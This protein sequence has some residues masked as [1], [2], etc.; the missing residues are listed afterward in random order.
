MRKFLI[1]VSGARPEILDRCPT[2]R[3][4]FQSL[5]LL[6]LIAGGAAAV[7]MWFALTSALGL[8]LF[9]AV[10]VALLA[11]L[12]VTAIDRWLV[13]SI[14]S[15]S[16]RRWMIAIPRLVMAMLLGIVI[17]TPLVLR[18]FQPEINAQIAV[19]KQQQVSAFLEQQQHSPISEQITY[20]RSR[21][22]GLQN[23]VDSDGDVP[24]NLAI[25]P[26]VRSLTTQL[27]TEQHLKQQ[28]YKQW[29]CQLYGEKGCL[30]GNGQLARAN[31]LAY[32]EA[33]VQVA[34]LTG[35]I[36]VREDQLLK[37]AAASKQLRYQQASS[38]LPR[39]EQQLAEV[40][41]AQNELLRDFN[42]QNNSS[43]GLLIRL[44]ALNELSSSNLTV[45][46][47][48]LLVFFLFLIIEISPTIVKL[49]QRDGNYEKILHIAAEQELREA[50]R[51]AYRTRPGIPQIPSPDVDWAASK[52]AGIGEIWS[53][54]RHAQLGRTP[55]DEGTHGGRA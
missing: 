54:V 36:H 7:S 24:I 38:E 45:N 53:H 23:V 29:Q 52:E 20:W 31:Q 46:V 50:R 39:A 12:V 25:D 13:I 47:S 28:Y 41:Q 17:S 1:T 42:T 33:A 16:A 51:R 2:D 35:R 49:A 9:M 27:K 10:P 21:V 48:R 8:N 32:N 15:G 34:A 14:P 22:V 18:I 26:V 40:Q 3:V 44:Q 4:R 43:D 37:D 30:G 6:I 55:L 11:G 5:G 19:V